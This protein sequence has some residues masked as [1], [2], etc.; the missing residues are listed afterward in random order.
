M[1]VAEEMRYLEGFNLMLLYIECA[2]GWWLIGYGC[3]L[4]LARPVWNWCWIDLFGYSILACLG[5]L[6]PLALGCLLLKNAEFW[7][8]PIFKRKLKR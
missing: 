6:L 5:P 7:D 8:K 2:V 1:G 4:Y 3:M